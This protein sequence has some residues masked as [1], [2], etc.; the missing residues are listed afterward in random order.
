ML[1]KKCTKCKVEK[2][3]T[4]EFFP[5]QK[6]GKYGLRADCK[7]C[8][9]Q[10]NKKRYRDPEIKKGIQE[11]HQTPNVKQTKQRYDEE[12]RQRPDII[13]KKKIHEKEYYSRTE[14]KRRKREYRKTDRYKDYQQEYHAKASSKEKRR[15]RQN[16][17]YAENQVYRTHIL[18][19]SSLN[20]MMQGKKS[21]KC[22]HYLGC[23]IEQLITHLDKSKPD[24][25]GP[26]HIDHI[27]PKSLYNLTE[28]D[29]CRC[30]NY[31]NLRLIPAS[32]N[33]AKSD[34]LDMDLVRKYDIKDL[35]PY[36]V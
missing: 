13:K 18:I 19:A 10:Y 1:T 31:A 25:D 27:I 33:L 16:K 5:R 32:H 11:L 22:I 28:K 23:S 4:I 9:S 3:A 30:W 2:S 36:D 34:T 21:K 14:V 26:F 15:I 20:K 35:L 24:C 7:L 17:R 29:L 12:Y 8:N 6:A